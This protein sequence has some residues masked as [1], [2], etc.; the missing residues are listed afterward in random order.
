MKKVLITGSN[1]FLG[2]H[3]I[4]KLYNYYDL[5][6]MDR[7]ATKNL[8]T[9][10][11]LVSDIGDKEKVSYIFSKVKPDIVIHLAAIV[12]KNSS[13]T[14]EANYNYVNYECSKNIFDLCKLYNV[15]KVI[16]SST[17]EV[18]GDTDEDYIDETTPVN[19]KSYYAKSK[20]LAEQYL[21]SLFAET[22]IEYA[23]LRL[24][25]VYAKDFKMNIEKRVFIKPNEIA[26]Y[27]K[28]GSYSYQFLSVNNILEF[29]SFLL[30]DRFSSGIYLL[31]DSV[32]ISA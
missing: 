6:G 10:H 11:S 16:F 9:D 4:A 18:Y 14:S 26:Y 5:Y 15:S 19:P 17:I 12:H 3:L 8:D 13:D 1:G 24:C 2:Q 23:I 32:M 25:P 7:V 22:K 20:L 27:F 21:I 28:N 29:V 30:H 31:S